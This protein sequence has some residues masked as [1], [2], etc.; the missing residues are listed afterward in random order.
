MAKLLLISKNYSKKRTEPRI[1]IKICSL[2]QQIVLQLGK[3]TMET[4]LRELFKRQNGV[5]VRLEKTI[6]IIQKTFQTLPNKEYKGIFMI[7]KRKIQDLI[8]IEQIKFVHDI[9]GFCQNHL[10]KR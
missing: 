3:I 9:S 5:S 7:M 2:F 4:Y 10:H 8:D 6:R 1:Y